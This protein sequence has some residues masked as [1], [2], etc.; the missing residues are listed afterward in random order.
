MWT[1]GSFAF[2]APWMLL[3]LAGVPLLWWLLRLTPPAPRRL[4]FPAIRLL[5]DLIPREETPHRL[6]A[7]TDLIDRAEREGRSVMLLT[8]APR[9]DGQPIAATGVMTATQARGVVQGLAPKPWA[10]DRRGALTAV[11][12]IKAQ[13]S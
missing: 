9:A 7:M 4:Q 2:A 12:R 6:Q 3:T 10:T 11:E 5:L 1:I 13:G 8:T